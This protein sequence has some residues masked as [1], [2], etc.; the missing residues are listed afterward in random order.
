[1]DLN[2]LT[3][4]LTNL[5]DGDASLEETLTRLKNFPAETLPDACLDH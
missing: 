4:F 1:M 5:R 2:T 3:S